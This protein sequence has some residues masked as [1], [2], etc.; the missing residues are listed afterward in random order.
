MIKCFFFLDRSCIRDQ[1]AVKHHMKALLLLFLMCFIFGLARSHLF[2][3][4]SCFTR[5]QLANK[6]PIKSLLHPAGFSIRQYRSFP[7][8]EFYTKCSTRVGV[9]L[10][11]HRFSGVKRRSIFLPRLSRSA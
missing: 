5:S 3:S 1:K 11:R 6:Q 9:G 7:G 8:R 10:S 2:L 4:S